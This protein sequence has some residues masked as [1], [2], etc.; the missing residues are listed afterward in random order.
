MNKKIL[1]I[2][3]LLAVCVTAVT[4]CTKDSKGVSF[5]TTYADMTMNGP[6]TLFWELGEAFVD[7]GCEAK[8]GETDLTSQIAAKSNVD[9]TK[10][11]IYNIT[12]SVNNSDGYPA[13]V[14]RTVIVYEKSAPL[15]GY[16]DSK[17]DRDNAGV[18]SS[19]G[20]F[21]VLVFGVG[22]NEYHIQDLLGR[23]YDLG[24]S[25]GPAY[26]G[27]GVIKLKGDNTF[28]IVSAEP[29]AWG[30]PCLFTDVSTYTPA[31]KT[32]VLHTRME[33]VATM[34]FKVTLNNP[35]PIE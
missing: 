3:I 4:S 20:P 18:K 11:G 30:Y 23:W 34:L 5:M 21:S 9:A 31:T 1:N 19:R 35:S 32:L 12:Y 14:S 6:S 27:P 28:E 8:E 22:N 33:D 25:Y 24:N 7:P 26:A 2:L 10:G 13:S 17:I 29:L 15:N 16:Y